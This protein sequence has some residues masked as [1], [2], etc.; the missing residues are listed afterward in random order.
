MVLRANAAIFTV[1][2]L[3]EGVSVS[4][5]ILCFLADSSFSAASALSFICFSN[6]SKDKSNRSFSVNKASSPGGLRDKGSDSVSRVVPCSIF[7]HA[8]K[9]PKIKIISI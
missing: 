6:V 4:I 2:A 8:N 1:S 9:V 3:W 7:W 5:K